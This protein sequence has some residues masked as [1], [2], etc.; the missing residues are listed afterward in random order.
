MWQIL[1]K[2]SFLHDGFICI[3]QLFIF[4]LT[5][6]IVRIHHSALLYNHLLSLASLKMGESKLGGS[7]CGRDNISR[8]KT[9]EKVKKKVFQGDFLGLVHE[10]PLLNGKWINHQYKHIMGN[11]S[12]IT[13]NGTWIGFFVINPEDLLICE[14]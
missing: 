10:T 7:N 14:T 12:L 11:V 3:K 5:H 1:V 2:L 6:F 9:I 4:V 8:F 13:G